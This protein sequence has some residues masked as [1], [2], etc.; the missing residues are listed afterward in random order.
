VTENP[1][2]RAG[3]LV[4]SVRGTIQIRTKSSAL[5]SLHLGSRYGNCGPPFGF[6]AWGP[7]TVQ[8]RVNRDGLI[9]SF[10]PS[11]P[12]RHIDDRALDD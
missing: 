7:S 8:I 1:Y 5:R 12:L 6:R 9:A 10:L 4:E 3:G 11:D 2:G